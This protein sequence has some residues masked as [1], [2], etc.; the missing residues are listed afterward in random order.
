MLWKSQPPSTA[1]LCGGTDI[2]NI[3]DCVFATAN[4]NE[5]DDWLLIARSYTIS[6][7]FIHSTTVNNSLA[8][9]SELDSL[10]SRRAIQPC[11]QQMFA[12]AV[13]SKPRGRCLISSFAILLYYLCLVSTPH[14]F[15]LIEM[16]CV[17]QVWKQLA[18]LI[19]ASSSLKVMWLWI[20]L[21]AIV[22]LP[23]TSD[24]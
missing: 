11:L 3:T 14:C 9:I 1:N 16:F 20:C 2:V 23:E 21:L 22:W 17:G 24:A 13:S 12:S 4:C 19:I 8:N 18:L 15:S 7:S 10:T 5:I 6:G